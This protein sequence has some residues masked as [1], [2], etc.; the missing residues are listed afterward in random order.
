VWISQE[1]VF[2]PGMMTA[3]MQALPEF[4]VAPSSH[5]PVSRYH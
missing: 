5:A 3:T 4:P 2:S 1:L